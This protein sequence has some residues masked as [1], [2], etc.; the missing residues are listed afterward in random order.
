MMPRI[1]AAALL[2]VAWTTAAAAASLEQILERGSI[3][4]CV[5]LIDPLLTRVEP[6]G[7]TADC[8]YAGVIVEEARAFAAALGVEP[9][10]R[11]V[12][13]SAQFADA[14]G[15]VRREAS[16]TPALLADGTCNLFV[17]NLARLPWRLTKLAIVPRF[18]SRMIAL[19]RADDADRISRVEDLQGLTIAVA[20]Q[21]SFHS[22]VLEQNRSVFA[23]RPI[24]IVPATGEEPLAALLRGEV[25]FVLTDADIA[26]SSLRSWAPEVQVAF[27]IG[28]VHEIG[29]GLAH[30]SPALEARIASF[31]AAEKAQPSSTTNRA[32]MAAFGVSLAEFEA[33]VRALLVE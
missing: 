4:I 9:R 25:D 27:A 8:R 10:F 17:S 28:P 18:N 19:I 5:A 32:W 24:G 20:E 11:T 13:W 15:A 7:C 6:A 26:V 33:L 23:A 12:E 16:Y 14:S 21:S 22:W 29:W 2:V 30:G 31:F 1:F 3:R